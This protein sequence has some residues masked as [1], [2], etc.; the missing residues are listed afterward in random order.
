MPGLG[1]NAK[2]AVVAEA[3]VMASGRYCT[4]AAPTAPLPSAISLAKY[5]IASYDQGMNGTCFP[6]GTHVRMADGSERKIEDVRLLDTVVTAE[7]NV[8]RVMQLMV[9]DYTGPLV[10]LKVWGHSHL[11]MTPEHPVL[12]E[13]GYVKEDSRDPAW[14]FPDEPP[15]PKSRGYVKAKDLS[16]DDWVAMPKYVANRR[17]RI[18]VVDHVG[19]QRRASGRDRTVTYAGVRGRPGLHVTVKA[20]PEFIALTPE[21]GWL[22]GV[23][24][25]EGSTEFGKVI[26]TFNIN[27]LDT[28]VARTVAVLRSFGLDPA[29]ATNQDRHVAVVKLYGSLWARLF[30]S[31]GSAGSGNKRLHPELCGGPRE[32]LE[33]VFAGWMD[34]DGSARARGVRGVSISQELALGMYDIAQAVGMLP[35]ILQAKPVS[36]RYALVRQPRWEVSAFSGE[37]S[38]RARQDDKHVWRKIRGIEL[39]YYEG[40]VYNIGV[41]GDNSY[42]AEGIGVHNCWVH[43]AKQLGEVMGRALGYDVYPICRMLI[44]WYAKQ[45]YEGGGNPGDGGSPTDAIRAMAKGGVGIAHESLDPYSD[46]TRRLGQRP[47]PEVWE[48]AGDTHLLAPVIVKSLDQAKQLIASGRPVCNGIPWPGNW[49]GPGPVVGP[50]GG[51]VGGHSVLMIGFCA[52]GVIDSH[53]CL[54]FDNWRRPTQYRVLPPSLAALVPGY[55][56]SRPT[57]TT[58]FWIREDQY[59][60]LCRGQVTEHISAT[61]LD[62]LVKGIVDAGPSFLDAIPI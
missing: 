6:P 13:R 20:L 55:A 45:E 18:A 33:Q 16:F 42:V 47:P 57:T 8:G 61:D 40:P 58:D 10:Q 1:W 4:V 25:A 37:E 56:P 44:G 53:P 36:N 34:G 60:D 14:L 35:S 52:A 12:S 23:F 24:L 7:G 31:L 28:L 54:Q 59:L 19:A 29:I 27:E 50:A 48:D 51:I 38:Y 15:V 9:R 2:R 26:W 46:D 11:F 3:E 30:E 32:F 43:S 21:F 17:D 62:G 5:K 39:R 41:E 49:E 22:V